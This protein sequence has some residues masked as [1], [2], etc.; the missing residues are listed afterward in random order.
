[1]AI[2]DRLKWKQ[3]I[4]ERQPWCMWCGEGRFHLEIHE[5]ERRSHAKHPFHRCNYLLLCQ[6]CHA[7]HFAAMKHDQQL[8]VKAIRDW[9]H[10]DLQAWLRLRDPELAAPE[11]VTE[12]EVLAWVLKLVY[13][14]EGTSPLCL[15]A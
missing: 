9:P 8:A 3:E 15:R 5:I 4:S 2:N 6:D 11:R 7:N 10:Y 13:D 14:C 12:R 1:M